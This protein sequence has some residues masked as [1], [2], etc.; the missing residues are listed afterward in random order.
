MPSVPFKPFP[1]HEDLSDSIFIIQNDLLSPVKDNSLSVHEQLLWVFK[2]R[3]FQMGSYITRYEVT[4]YGDCS[5]YGTPASLL[6]VT[7]KHAYQV[8]AGTRIPAA[9]GYF[10]RYLT[11]LLGVLCNSLQ[12]CYFQEFPSTKFFTAVLVM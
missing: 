1:V 9:N 6:P 12:N 11:C 5:L 7:L 2:F 4:A 8:T 10:Y 3:L